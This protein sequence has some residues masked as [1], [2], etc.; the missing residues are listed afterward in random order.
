MNSQFLN[1]R[2]LRT[3]LQHP[4]P[5]EKTREGPEKLESFFL[6]FLSFLHPTA[7]D[8]DGNQ[9]RIEKTTK[10]KDDNNG[11]KEN[12]NLAVGCDEEESHRLSLSFRRTYKTCFSSTSAEV[13]ITV[14]DVAH[15]FRIIIFL[16]VAKDFP[17][18]LELYG[19]ESVSENG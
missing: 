7:L 18:I 17:S 12:V 13:A 1:I 6:P 3:S 11:H 2:R 14:R 16:R 19:V 10:K 5:R 9:R 15:V 4:I 8:L